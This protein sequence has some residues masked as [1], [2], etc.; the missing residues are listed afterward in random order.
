[1][2]DKLKKELNAFEQQSDN[3]LSVFGSNIPRLLRRIEEEFKKGRFKEKPRGPIGAYLKMKDAA[4]APAV[5]SY[6]SFRTLCSF[7]VDNTQD[8]KLLGSI[9]KEIFYNEKAPQIISS[10]F[11]SK[12]RVFFAITKISYILRLKAQVFETQ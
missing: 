1:M 9:M 6:L 11:Y 7:C 12:V 10:K 5:E 4:W 3:A 2:K 8:A